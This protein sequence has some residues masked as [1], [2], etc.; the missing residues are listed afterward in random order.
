VQ[1]FGIGDYEILRVEE[2]VFADIPPDQFLADLPS[3]A[4]QENLSWL[5]P[6]YYEETSGKLMSSL[7]SWIVRT[8]HQNV[9]IDTCCGNDKPRSGPSAL[10][11]RLSTP[12][13]DRFLATGLT[14]SDIDFVICT[15]L[16][17]DHVGWNTRLVGDSWEPT[18]PNARYLFGRKEYDFWR[19][20]Q[21]DGACDAVND[22]NVFV[23]SIE[24]I[25]D[26][27][28]ADFVDDG[29]EVADGV[30]IEAAYGHTRG[31][32]VVRVESQGRHGVFTG[33]VIHTPLQ[34]RYPDVNTSFCK[35]PDLA[36]AT[37]LRILRDCAER[38]IMLF[39]AHFPHP[40]ACRVAREGQTFRL[41]D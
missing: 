25:L 3:N 10:C 9:L 31:H 12:Y 11:D 41:V 28:L 23:D 14:S 40:W 22:E 39:P 17:V 24:P 33:D 26:A 37:R 38:G 4:V 30:T 32:L 36:R 16:H 29:F 8:P 35:D 34:I 27:G 21:S 20:V 6:D 19:S 15:H 13:M 1:T 7:H 5:A 18:F 2:M